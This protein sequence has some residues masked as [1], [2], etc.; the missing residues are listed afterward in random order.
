[1][2]AFAA[3]KLGRKAAFRQPCGDEFGAGR[4]GFAGRIDRLEANQFGGELRDFVAAAVDGA[5]ELFGHALIEQG[6]HGSGKRV[7]AIF[8]WASA[9]AVVTAEVSSSLGISAP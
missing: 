4:I 2:R 5:E 7:R 9:H 8:A 6:W 3:D 1:G